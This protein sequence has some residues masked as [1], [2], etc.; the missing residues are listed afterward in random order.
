METIFRFHL[1]RPPVLPDPRY[2]AL[3]LSQDTPFQVELARAA[4]AQQNPGP[5]PAKTMDQVANEYLAGPNFVDADRENPGNLKLDSA[6]AKV[7]K[8]ALSTD[9]AGELAVTRDVLAAMLNDTLGQDAIAFSR[10]GS[11]KELFPRLIDSIVAIRQ[12]HVESPGHM[13]TLASRLRLLDLI[14]RMATDENFPLGRA[15]L[16]AW[17]LR[18]LLAPTMLDLQSVLSAATVREEAQKKA[19]ER[20]HMEFKRGQEIYAK[21]LDVKSALGHLRAIPNTQFRRTPVLERSF[22]APAVDMSHKVFQDRKLQIVNTLADMGKLH[23][24]AVIKSGNLSRFASADPHDS[25]GALLA[26][27]VPGGLLQFPDAS[28]L[29]SLVDMSKLIFQEQR[30]LELI[31]DPGAAAF[32]PP[33]SRDL[34]PT[35]TEEAAKNVPEKT[36]AFLSQRG[37]LLSATP[38]ADAIRNLEAEELNHSASLDSLYSD[39]DDNVQTSVTRAGNT[40]IRSRSVGLPSW[41]SALKTGALQL[42]NF[43]Q[44][45]RPPDSRIPNSKGRATIAGVCDLLVVKQ[46]L[47]DYEGADVAH[48]ESVLVGEKKTREVM[49]RREIEST[50]YSETEVTTEQASEKATVE[51][52]ETAE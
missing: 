42:P 25:G 21:L 8:L 28:G 26:A 41:R 33:D 5:I 50:E 52:F 43:R 45:E 1:L 40:L 34:V 30:D 23:Y 15:D 6:A 18:T 14:G 29:A 3:Q 13:E 38:L 7:A 44:L 48:I 16:R 2:P 22:R 49:T 32:A 46:Q 35:L 36:K 31:A 37:V 47:I 19:L 27:D 24:E 51:R 4:A 20:L 9:E 17:W 39:F 12:A 10:A 11:T